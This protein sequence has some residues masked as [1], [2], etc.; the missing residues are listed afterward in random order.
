MKNTWE[1]MGFFDVWRDFH[2]L[3]RDFSHCLAAHSVY[4]RINYFFM[5]K[6]NRHKLQGCYIGVADVSDHNATCLKICLSSSQKDT[7]WRLNVGILN[8][9]LLVEQIKTHSQCYLEENDN[10]DT[11]PAILWDALKAVIHGKLNAITSNL[12]KEK[13]KQYK[14]LETEL[15]QLEQKH[16]GKIDQKIQ[17]HMKEIKKKLTNYSNRT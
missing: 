7:I 14:T 9:K 13:V 15:K 5:Q 10:G 6:E 11:N 16:K 4:S 17:Q 8:N 3:W 2:P 12:K 1:E